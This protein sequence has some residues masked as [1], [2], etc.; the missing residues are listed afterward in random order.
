MDWHLRSGQVPKGAWS[1]HDCLLVGMVGR[2]IF[3][4]KSSPARNKK[5]LEKQKNVQPLGGDVFFLAALPKDMH[6]ETLIFL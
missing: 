6:A 3:S 2:F 1:E 4:L 5:Q